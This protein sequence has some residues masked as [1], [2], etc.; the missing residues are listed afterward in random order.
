MALPL[1]LR[2]LLFVPG[3]SRKKL[4]KGPATGADALV[5]D[6]EDAVPLDHKGSARNLTLEFLGRRTVPA[7]MVRVNPVSSPLFLEDCETLAG[8]LPDGIILSKCR[9]AADVAQ[10]EDFLRRKNPDAQCSIYPLIESPAAVVNAFSIAT[11]SN[12]VLGLGFGAEDFSAEA[13]IVRTEEEI[14]LLYARSAM[15]TACRAAGC[16]P[17]DSPCMDFQDSQKIRAAARRA[18]YL[19]FTGKFAIHPSQVHVI[20]ELFSPTES[21]VAA[22]RRVLDAFAAAGGAVLGLD[23][24]VVDEAVARRARQILIQAEAAKRSA[25]D[26]HGSR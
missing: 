8:S 15:V 24:T 25:L 2:S 4:E 14:E 9:S 12:R 17:I 1:L 20:N 13:R 18:R 3:D 19:G 21:E 16:E 7:W 23:G 22:A 6:W 11:S 26:G 5:V 10:L